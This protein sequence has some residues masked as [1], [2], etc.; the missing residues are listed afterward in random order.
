[1]STEPA[2]QFAQQFERLSP[3]IC[4]EWPQVDGDALAKTNGDYHSVVAL[5]STET[6]HSKTLVKKQLEEL[7]TIANENGSSNN[8]LRKIRQMVERLQAKSQDVT[9]Y[10]RGQMVE[11]TRAKVVKSPLASLLMAVGFG[12]L[13]AMILRGLGR[14][15][16]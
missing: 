5:I 1:M 16:S 9:A 11:E 7:S 10:V 2:T 4:E 6:D 3:M 15:R 14:G 13:L 12:F 8:E